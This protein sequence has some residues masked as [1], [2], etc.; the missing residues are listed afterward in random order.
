MTLRSELRSYIR[1]IL[2]DQSTWP[3]T[4][5]NSWISDAIRDYSIYFPLRV[6]ATIDC[7]ADTREY[8]LTSYTGIMGLTLVEYP[9][10]EDP[11]RYLTRRPRSGA[12]FLDL[13]VYD[14]L[15]DPP[16]KLI[17]GEEPEATEDIFI[18]YMAM[19]T[20]PTADDD[21]LTMP[22]YHF[23]GIKLF[24]QWQAVKALEMDEAQD[25][26]TTSILLSML[27]LNSGRAERLYRTKIREYIA[28]TSPGGY[29]GPWSSDEYDRVY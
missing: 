1:Q 2:I 26:N 4:R 17:I 12:S 11:P 13:P 19:H 23:E 7:L 29:A 20:I 18:V 3:A 22:D 14:I 5:L 27:G 28:K 15:G 9:K 8:S 6:E 25:P 10:G 21:T 24:V 16:Q